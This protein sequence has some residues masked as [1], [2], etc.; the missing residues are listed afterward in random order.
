MFPEDPYI[1]EMAQNTYF[2]IHLYAKAARLSGYDGSGDA[3]KS[4]ELGWSIEAPEGSVFL[5]PGTHPGCAHYIRLAVCD[6]N[7]NVKFVRD[8]PSIQAWWLQRLGVD[9]IRHPE[10]KQYTPDEDPY[11]KMFLKKS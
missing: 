5:Q 3:E 11:F 6:E 9:L 10:Y 8:W 4:V 1:G 7:H 2:T